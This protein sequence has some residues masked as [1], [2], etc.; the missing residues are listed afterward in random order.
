[1]VKSF[2]DYEKDN[3]LGGGSGNFNPGAG[4][5]SGSGSGSSSSKGAFSQNPSTLSIS[6]VGKAADIARCEA[7]RRKLQA[8]AEL[9]DMNRTVKRWN[10]LSNPSNYKFNPKCQ[11]NNFCR[12]RCPSD[13]PDFPLPHEPRG[14]AEGSDSDGDSDDDDGH[15][16]DRQLD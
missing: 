7:I 12:L 13:L 8:E 4:S 5:G 11:L 9:E 16:E 15:S 1:V 10:S 3:S 2:A 6:A 14:A